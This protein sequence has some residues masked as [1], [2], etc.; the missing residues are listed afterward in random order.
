MYLYRGEEEKEKLME[1]KQ[2]Q[3]P[4]DKYDIERGSNASQD[5]PWPIPRFIE[6]QMTIFERSKC[7]KYM[8]FCCLPC[9]N[10]NYYVSNISRRELNS[11][12]KL[13][14]IAIQP[15]NEKV[16]YHEDSLKN[17][18]LNCFKSELTDDLRNMEWKN[19]GFQVKI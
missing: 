5:R 11:Y 1:T 6:T 17:L 14:A 7:V 15:Y 13:L 18:Y 9:V 16:V 12:Y 3:E 2:K 10:K 19:I 8:C 4:F